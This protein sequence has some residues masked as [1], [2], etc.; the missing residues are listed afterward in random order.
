M[1]AR[2]LGPVTKDGVTTA[3][4]QPLAG[5]GD[6]VLHLGNPP[7]D[8]GALMGQF[9]ASQGEPLGVAAQSVTIRLAPV[10]STHSKLM[11]E[12]CNLNARP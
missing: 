2:R 4:S 9:P 1:L 5:V 10:R 12:G 3:I 8:L 7:F 6:L 11:P